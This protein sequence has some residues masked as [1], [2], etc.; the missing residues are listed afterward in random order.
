MLRLCPRGQENSLFFTYLF[1]HR[2]LRE[3]RVLLTDVDHADRQML[4]ERADQLWAHYAQRSHS[5][6]ACIN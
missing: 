5:T 4:S 1:L 2:L 3:L 6:V